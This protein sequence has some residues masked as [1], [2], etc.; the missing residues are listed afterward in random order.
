MNCILYYVNQKK[1]ET[2]PPTLEPSVFYASICDDPELSK[3]DCK[4]LDECEWDKQEDVCLTKADG[5]AHASSH[6]EGTHATAESA[7]HG[8]GGS[9]DG[10]SDNEPFGESDAGSNGQANAIAYDQSC[11]DRHAIGISHHIFVADDLDQTNAIAHHNPIPNEGRVSV[12]PP[13]AEQP[14]LRTVEQTQTQSPG[15][16]TGSFEVYIRNVERDRD[17]PD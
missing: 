5:F 13:R 10:G 16:G 2:P 4:D 6:H 7:S 8:D 3:R 17:Q 15:H 9:N 14:A 11:P 1:Q 12:R